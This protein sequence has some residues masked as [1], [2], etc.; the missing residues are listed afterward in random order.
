M[1]VLRR[2]GSGSVVAVTVGLLV[3]VV[4]AGVKFG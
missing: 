1:H 2:I 4:G 3:T